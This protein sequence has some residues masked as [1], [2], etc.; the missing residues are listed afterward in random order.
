MPFNNFFWDFNGSTHV[1]L[2]IETSSP[3]ISEFALGIFMF[4]S[5]TL[6]RLSYSLFT[7]RAS[8]CTSS[9]TRNGARSYNEEVDIYASS[10]FGCEIFLDHHP[11]LL[12]VN[13]WRPDKNPRLREYKSR[14]EQ[15]LRSLNHKTGAKSAEKLRPITRDKSG[16]GF[17][18]CFSLVVNAY[19]KILCF[20]F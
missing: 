10:L 8:N 9:C 16:W 15:S 19:W 20:Q 18:E 1:V 17:M 3:A 5:S 11:W 2:C 13:P 6:V 4:Q 12:S 14:H 7:R